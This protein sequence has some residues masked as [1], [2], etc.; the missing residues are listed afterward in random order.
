MARLYLF[1][2]CKLSS[3]LKVRHYSFCSTGCVNKS[4]SD[5]DL[6][7]YTRSGESCQLKI[8]KYSPVKMVFFVLF[9][10]YTFVVTWGL[11]VILEEGWLFGV[12]VFRGMGFNSKSESIH[13]YICLT[14]K[15]SHWKT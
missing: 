6:K 9:S 12:G 5:V 10:L 3:N 2:K 1:L 15:T 13:L 7:N 8:C 11:W 4:N 14:K